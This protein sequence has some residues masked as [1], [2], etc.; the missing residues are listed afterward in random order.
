[1]RSF[2]AQLL[3]FFCLL[4]MAFFLEV[5]VEARELDYFIFASSC[6]S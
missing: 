2:Y 4:A 5:N 3:L 1:M 6:S